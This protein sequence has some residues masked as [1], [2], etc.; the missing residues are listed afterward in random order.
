LQVAPDLRLV[1][2][3]DPLVELQEV[4]DFVAAQ[5]CAAWFD[6]ITTAA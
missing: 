6:A 2:R 1:L 3:G 4:P 5:L